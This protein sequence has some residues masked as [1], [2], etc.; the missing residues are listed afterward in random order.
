MLQAINTLLAADLYETC[1]NAV[2]TGPQNK[3]SQSSDTS[4][5]SSGPI[6]IVEQLRRTLNLGQRN[7]ERIKAR[8][9]IVACM[10]L[11]V[12]L[13]RVPALRAQI[14]Q[15][16]HLFLASEGIPTL[17]AAT[18]EMLFTTMQ[19]LDVADDGS[20]ETHLEM[21]QEIED[22]LLETAW[23]DEPVASCEAKTKRL[24]V[25]LSDIWRL[26]HAV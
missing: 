23:A 9:R 14:L 12:N 7:I 17:R 2:N 24:I 22:V 18:A 11:N 26:Q 25:M 19:E 8:P 15:K 6:Q 13:L 16:L 20:E 5:A 1:L 21:M 4:T 10:Q 3:E